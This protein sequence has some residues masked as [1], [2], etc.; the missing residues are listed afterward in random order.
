VIEYRVIWWERMAGIVEPVPFSGPVKQ[1]FGD[2]ESRLNFENRRRDST[3]PRFRVTK[4]FIEARPAS[5]APWPRF[6]DKESVT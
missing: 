2:V 5:S 6:W 3:C 4:A 1:D